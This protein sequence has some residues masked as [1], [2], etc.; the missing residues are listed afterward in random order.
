VETL[1]PR[2]R[3]S[4]GAGRFPGGDGVRRVY[5]ALSDGIAV[6]IRGERFQRVPEGSAGGGAPKPAAA[7]I[8]RAGGAVEILGPRSAVVLDR[9]DRLIVESCGGAGYGAA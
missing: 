2:R 5:E 1:P 4:G 7:Q 6:S 3:G 9:G 8:R